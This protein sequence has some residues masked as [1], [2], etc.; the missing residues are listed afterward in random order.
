MTG[1]S[2]GFG[3]ILLRVSYNI[4]LMSVLTSMYDPRPPTLAA[5]EE[6]RKTLCNEEE[7]HDMRD[8]TTKKEEHTYPTMSPAQY[9]Q[10]V[11]PNSPV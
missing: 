6:D 4:F 11:A 8:E 1:A 2:P 3:R 7:L 5:V 10:A 9:N